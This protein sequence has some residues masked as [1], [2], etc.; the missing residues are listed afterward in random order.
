M[1]KIAYQVTAKINGQSWETKRTTLT[2]ENIDA[3]RLKAINILRLKPEHEIEI[4]EVE[5]FASTEK[6]TTDNYP[7]GRLKC[8]AYFSLEFTKNGFRSVFQ[9]INPK[10]DRLNN[11]KNSTY[12]SLMLPMIDKSTGHIENCGH[13]TFNGDDDINRGLYFI[14]DFYELFTTEQIEYLAICLLAASKITAK[15][16]VIYCG[17]K[18]EDLKDVIEPSIKCLVNIVKTKENDFLNALLDIDKINALKVPNYQ[19]FKATQYSSI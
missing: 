7:Y 2:A 6:L 19:P 1:K 16:Q 11:P 15:A 5:V 12:Y 17:T 8:T 14:N 4:K 3:A 10:N 18:W 9:T 13:N